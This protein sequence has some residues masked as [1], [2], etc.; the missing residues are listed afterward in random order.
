MDMV[1]IRMASE[2]D[3]E[4]VLRVHASAVR[5]ICKSHY[6][7]EEIKAW[8]EEARRKSYEPVPES[9]IVLVAEK[10]HKVVGFAR[11][12][13]D[14]KEVTSLYVHAEHGGQGIGSRLLGKLEDAAREKGINLLHLHSTL[15][16]VSFYEQRGYE[17]KETIKFPLNEEVQLD[18][19]YMEKELRRD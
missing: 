4:A 8:L 6:S 15:N 7:E 17:A 19:V 18:C 10:E 11:L 1:T 14:K 13:V 3:R 9:Y 2:K 16:S 5:G 12:D